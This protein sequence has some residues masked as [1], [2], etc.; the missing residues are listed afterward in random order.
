MVIVTRGDTPDLPLRE[1]EEL[2]LK[3]WSTSIGYNLA[4]Q[5][6]LS[7]PLDLEAWHF[8]LRRDGQL[9]GCGRISLHEDAAR[10]PDRS[11]FSSALGQI[12]FPCCVMNRL[13]VA[14]W[15]RGQRL[16][17]AIDEARLILA[18]RKMALE[19]WVE[20]QGRRIERLQRLGFETTERSGDSEIAG[21][22][23]ILRKSLVR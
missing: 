13:V 18:R 22:W 10:F 17:S 12:R 1:I 21:D 5:R 3:V 4:N 16:A 8:G 15:C 2:R 14:P 11:S 20:A 6:F 7:D 19:V 23:W 9:A